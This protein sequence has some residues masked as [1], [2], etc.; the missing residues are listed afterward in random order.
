[1]T[2]WQLYSRYIDALMCCPSEVG[3]NQQDKLNIC[4]TVRAATSGAQGAP[5]AQQT[6]THSC[7]H[8]AEMNSS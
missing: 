6:E 3:V 4:T 7:A 1:M 5:C 8:S 2:E